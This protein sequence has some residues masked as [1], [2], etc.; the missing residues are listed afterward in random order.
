MDIILNTQ[1]DNVL[2]SLNGKKYNIRSF[3]HPIKKINL[4][5][6]ETS[7]PILDDYYPLHGLMSKKKRYANIFDES[8]QTKIKEYLN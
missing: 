5:M 2:I 3:K 8:M 4:F 6:F 7:K 1:N